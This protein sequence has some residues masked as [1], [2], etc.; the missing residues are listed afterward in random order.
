MK[1]HI[2]EDFETKTRELYLNGKKYD[3]CC[4]AK[5][6]KKINKMPDETEPLDQTINLVTWLIN[7]SIERNCLPD[8]PSEADLVTEDYV[9]YFI[10]STNLAAY[11]NLAYEC[12]YGSLPDEDPEEQDNSVITD[13]MREMFGEPEENPTTAG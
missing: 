1:A 5:V 7:D 12:I 10:N 11:R 8:K 2:I 13:E 3:V 9:E 4:S 6:L